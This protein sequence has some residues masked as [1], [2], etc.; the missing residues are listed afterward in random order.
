MAHSLELRVPF[1][2]K[3]LVEWWWSQPAALRF[4]ARNPKAAL[5]EAVSDLLP[6]HIL[7]RPKQGFTL[8]LARW[9]RRELKPFLDDTFSHAS[10]RAC[11]WLNA[12]AVGTQWQQFLAGADSAAWSRVWTLAM[13]VSFANNRPSPA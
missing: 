6:A 3:V 11:P 1:V 4:S 5:R 2:D 9:M 12:Q 10:L 7:A 13:L 8:P